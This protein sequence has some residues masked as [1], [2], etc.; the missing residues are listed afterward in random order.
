MVLSP[1]SSYLLNHSILQSS[2]EPLY[3]GANFSESQN[4]YLLLKA[5]K[6]ALKKKVEYQSAYAKALNLL[7]DKKNKDNG[8]EKLLVDF[9]D[10]KMCLKETEEK[11]QV[12]EISRL[13]KLVSTLMQGALNIEK[14]SKKTSISSEVP[15]ILHASVKEVQ[16]QLER[17]DILEDPGPS[18]DMSVPSII[19]DLQ[20]ISKALAKIPSNL[21]S[22]EIHE[23]SRISNSSLDKETLA[24]I[25]LD[26]QKLGAE[27]NTYLREISNSGNVTPDCLLQL[28]Q[29]FFRSELLS[30][31][32]YNIC[33]FNDEADNNLL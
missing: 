31:K 10:S 11:W 22:N 5:K 3:D 30:E 12:A 20:R 8:I 7:G 1:A 4:K 23:P 25:L 28:R 6:E 21:K 17:L 26:W 14:E 32:L 2:K 27:Q 16:S 33:S 29:Y 9:E 13:S 15:T 18:S 19:A 24:N